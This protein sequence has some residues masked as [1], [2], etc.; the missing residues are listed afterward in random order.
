MVSE[1]LSGYIGIGEADG[2]RAL[3]GSGSLPAGLLHL[4][5]SISAGREALEFI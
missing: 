1:V 2:M 3:G 4:G 5:H